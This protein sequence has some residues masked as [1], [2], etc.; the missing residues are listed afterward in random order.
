MDHSAPLPVLWGYD[1]CKAQHAAGKTAA[2]WVSLSQE[3]AE[4]AAPNV[5]RSK[6]VEILQGQTNDWTLGVASA[7]FDFNFG[8]G[9]GFEQPPTLSADKLCLTV[10]LAQCP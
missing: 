3:A 2:Q 9:F 1:E 6:I 4:E 7:D 5:P 8:V 10:S